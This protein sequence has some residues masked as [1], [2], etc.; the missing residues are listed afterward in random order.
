VV[1][2]YTRN[3]V[4]RSGGLLGSNAKG[5]GFMTLSSSSFLLFTGLCLLAIAA[6]LGFVQYRYRAQPEAFAHW[7][8]VHAGGSTGAV[9]LLALSAVWEKL[10]L[11]EDWGLLL[12]SSLSFATW[13]FVA[14]PLA[15]ALGFPGAAGR[16]NIVGAVVAVPAY[17]ALP[18]PLFF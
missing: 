17:V 7:R 14:G 1:Q 6:L 8:V 5:N 4:H 2:W 12:A 9:Q 13:A 16:I 3:A 11:A 18:L 10:A 15:R